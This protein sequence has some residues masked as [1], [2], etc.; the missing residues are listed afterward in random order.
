HQGTLLELQHKTVEDLANALKTCLGGLNSLLNDPPYNF[1]FH[2]APNK[3]TKKL[4]HWHLEVYPKLTIWAG[5]EKST[6]IYINVVPP[7]DS[8][9]NMRQT[10]ANLPQD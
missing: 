5:F 3:E 7:E 10:I 8:A 2:M 6:G 4:Y 1:G 9:Q